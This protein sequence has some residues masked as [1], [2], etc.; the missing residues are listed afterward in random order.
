MD[1]IFINLRVKTSYRKQKVRLSRKIFSIFSLKRLFSIIY[2]DTEFF[3]LCHIDNKLIED[4]NTLKFD[5]F[6]DNSE[7]VIY[8]KKKCTREC[9][10]CHKIFTTKHGFLYHSKNRVCLDNSSE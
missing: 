5:D 2:R 7:L 9:I 6:K 8:P 3:D 4:I 10:E 1:I